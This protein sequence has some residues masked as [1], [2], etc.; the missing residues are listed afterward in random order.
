MFSFMQNGI[1]SLQWRPERRQARPGLTFRVVRSGPPISNSSFSPRASEFFSA[2]PGVVPRAGI[3]PDSARL[4][5][6][7]VF[8]VFKSGMDRRPAPTLAVP[9]SVPRAAI[10]ARGAQPRW[11]LPAEATVPKAAVQSCTAGG[12][13]RPGTQPVALSASQAATEAAASMANATTSAM[14]SNTP[15]SSK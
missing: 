15:S 1:G 12:Y 9:G 10:G 14:P 13:R 11:R 3:F 8:K 7:L 2:R 4:F 6:A 5:S